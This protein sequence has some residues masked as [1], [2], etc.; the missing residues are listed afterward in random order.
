MLLASYL[1]V[2]VIWVAVGKISEKDCVGK[3][4]E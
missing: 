4:S 2:V 3:E 1:V